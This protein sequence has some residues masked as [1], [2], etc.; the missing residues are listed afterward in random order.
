MK[1]RI[2]G[3]FLLCVFFSVIR[4]ADKEYHDD[5]VVPGVVIVKFRE[6]NLLAKTASESG[7]QGVIE[8]YA[9]EKFEPVLSEA[10]GLSKKSRISNLENIYYTYYNSQASPFAVA[11]EIKNSST[12]ILYAEPKYLH[13]ISE[14]KVEPPNDSLFQQQYHL[15]NINAVEA[16]NITKSEQ[17]NTV[18]AIVDGGTEIN[19][20]DLNANFWNNPNEIP[21]DGIDNDNNG[22]IDDIYGW[23]FPNNNNDPTGIP[24]TPINANH[25]TH[26]AG[27]A[28]GVTD[29]SI[30]ISGVCL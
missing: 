20:P 9:I 26:T 13:F 12:E 30:G 23:N 7:L 5:K 25:G 28:S 6:S 18:I 11:Q 22:F 8:K 15:P 1:I 14:T 17:G 4:A 2:F 29:N 19:H 10:T 3:V 27:I 21:N 24:S 16:W